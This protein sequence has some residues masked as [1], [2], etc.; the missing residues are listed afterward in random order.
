MKK[1]QKNEKNTKGEKVL[2]KQQEYKEQ[3]SDH[4][5]RQI[6]HQNKH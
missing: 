1:K 3:Y 6:Q 2:N 5:L 4:I